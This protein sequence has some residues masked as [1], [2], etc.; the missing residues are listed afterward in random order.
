M[1]KSGNMLKFSVLMS[2]YDNEKPENLSQSLKSLANQTV[3]PEEVI[4]VE[5]GPISDELIK[6]IDWFKSESS[7]KIRSVSIENNVGLGTALAIGS[8]YVKTNL[9]ARMDTDDICLPNRFEQQLNEFANND[10]LAIVGGQI[11][12][13]I[14]STDNIV[15]YRKV[16]LNDS[17]I[18]KFAKLRSPFNHPTVMMKK[19]VLDRAGGYQK[20]ISLED[21][22]LWVRFLL[23][24]DISVRNIPDVVLYMRGDENMYRRRGGI[25]YFFNYVKLRFTFWRWHFINFFEM[26]IGIIAMFVSSLLSNK[27]RTLLYKRILRR[28]V[29]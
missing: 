27:V 19:D 14:D 13:F 22:H 8:K 17:E 11:A 26:M 4:L 15:G 16:P 10:N 7:L 28:E 9:I 20:F 5:D 1:I 23:L 6:V 2:V 25:K 12:E 3:A 24:K 21:Y 29:K 18:R